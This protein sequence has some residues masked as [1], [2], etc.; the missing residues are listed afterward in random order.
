MC[1]QATQRLLNALA[2]RSFLPTYDELE[3]QARAANDGA[4]INEVTEGRKDALAGLKRLE[5]QVNVEL[6]E[7]TNLIEGLSKD[8]SLPL[9]MRQVTLIEPDIASRGVRRA[10]C[11]SVLADHINA[12][13][14]EGYIDIDAVQ[15]D[16]LTVA[17]TLIDDQL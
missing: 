1:D 6:T 5:E 2:I 14:V 9:M 10:R 15:Q 4:L 3:A 13:V 7:Y 12:R 11:L 17:Q 16:M 8:Y